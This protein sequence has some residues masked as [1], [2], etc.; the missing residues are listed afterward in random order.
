MNTHQRY[1]K[2]SLQSEAVLV[3]QGGGSLGAYECGVYKKLYEHGIKFDILAGSSIGAINAS[4]I[5]SAQNA[6]KDSAE[7]LENFWLIISEDIKP[8]ALLPLLPP[9]LPLSSSSSQLSIDKMMA[10]ASSMYST[11]YGNPKAFLPRWFK[12]TSRDYYLPPSKWNYLYDSDPLKK[13][14]KEFIDFKY[15]KRTQNKN[16]EEKQ[17]RL[18]ITS[19]DI[20]KGEPVIFDSEKMDVDIDKIISCVGYPFYGITWS[21]DN[22]RYL[23]DGSLLTNTPMLDVIHASPKYDK[24]FYIVDV[25]PRQQKEI[26]TNMVEVWHRARDIIFMDK[27]DKNIQMLSNFERYLSLLKKINNILN[28]DDAR[29]DEKTKARLKE[30]EPEYDELAQRRGAIVKELTRIGRREKMH[31]LLEDADFSQYRIK[32]LIEEGEEDAERALNKKELHA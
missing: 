26:P 12:P 25:F 5:C 15:L 29:I 8:T 20:Q 16:R 28:A 32:K 4:I 9:F 11:I 3:L 23:W 31:F 2:E 1:Q 19:T 14:L 21:Y 7:V 24:E 6:N 30:L 22:G 27:T 17:S 13:T 10:I 18:I